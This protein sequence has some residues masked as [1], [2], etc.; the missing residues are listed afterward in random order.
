M[1]SFVINIRLSFVIS[2]G[3]QEQYTLYTDKQLFLLWQNF[4]EKCPFWRKST[5]PFNCSNFMSFWSYKLI[6][7]LCTDRNVLERSK[8]AFMH[9]LLIVYYILLVRRSL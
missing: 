4:D 3:S 9:N 5:G 1:F 6:F 2:V 8:I 7:K